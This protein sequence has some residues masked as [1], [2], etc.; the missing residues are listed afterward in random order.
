MSIEGFILTPENERDLTSAFT[1]SVAVDVAIEAVRR[2]DGIPN[3]PGCYF[4][5]ADTIAGRIKVYIG[6]TRS[7]RTRL[8][9]YATDFQPRSPDDY[10]MRI[11]WDW[12]LERMPDASFHLYFVEIPG[13]RVNRLKREAD[14]NRK[15]VPLLYR[16]PRSELAETTAFREAF[17]HYY[18]A[19]LSA[20]IGF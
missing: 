5:I 14:L 16:L 13:E 1:K 7:I 12:M 9:N 2:A 10:K 8:L 20:R 6:E 19:R 4:W 18:T 11:F 15:F 3:A 17:R